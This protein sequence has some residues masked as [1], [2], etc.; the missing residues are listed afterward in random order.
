M[1]RYPTG[2]RVVSALYELGSDNPYLAAM[3]SMLSKHE[4]FKAILSD[5]PLPANLSAMSS[6]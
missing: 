5:P 1:A 4:L 3:P 2:K 6:A